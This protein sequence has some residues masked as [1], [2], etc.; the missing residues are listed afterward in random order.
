M[1]GISDNCRTAATADRVSYLA[2]GHFPT[3]RSAYLVSA[4]PGSCYPV[5]VSTWLLG[6]LLAGV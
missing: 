1:S 6:V 5:P 2:S 4:I 3:R